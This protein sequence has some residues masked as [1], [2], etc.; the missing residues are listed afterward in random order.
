MNIHD[1]LP[2]GAEDDSRAPYNQEDFVS[3]PQCEGEGTETNGEPCHTCEGTGEISEYIYNQ[4]IK[5]PECDR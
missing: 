2:P 4:I 1:N 5:I 3:C